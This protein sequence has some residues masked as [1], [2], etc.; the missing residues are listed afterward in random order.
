MGCFVWFLSSEMVFFLNIA[1]APS[2]FIVGSGFQLCDYVTGFFLLGFQWTGPPVDSLEPPSSLSG[3]FQR[4]FFFRYLQRV[5]PLMSFI[6]VSIFHFGVLPSFTG[7]S[8]GLGAGGRRIVW[9]WTF[10]SL[11]LSLSLNQQRKPGKKLKKKRNVE[12]VIKR[13][14]RREEEDNGEAWRR[15]NGE[16]D[17]EDDSSYWAVLGISLS[18]SLSFLFFFFFTFTVFVSRNFFFPL[19]KR[20]DILF[21]SGRR[22]GETKK[23]K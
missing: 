12:E 15:D 10:L 21:R 23:N 8:V 20:Q 7:F 14:R 4:C 19:T 17:D 18:L 5:V 1:M 3:T 11:S 16:R 13:R 2:L 22:L 9:K 6:C